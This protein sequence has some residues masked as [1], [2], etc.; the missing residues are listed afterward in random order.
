M[1]FFLMYIQRH[2]SENQDKNWKFY[3]Y[4]KKSAFVLGEWAHTSLTDNM[5]QWDRKLLSYSS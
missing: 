2:F 4:T 1:G 5:R 3:T